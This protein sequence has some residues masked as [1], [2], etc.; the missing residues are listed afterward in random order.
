MAIVFV[1]RV[2]RV[3]VANTHTIVWI[4]LE[5]QDMSASW[6]LIQS[7][8]FLQNRIQSFTGTYFFGFVKIGIPVVPG[9]IVPVHKTNQM[10]TGEL[11][12]GQ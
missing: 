7:L 8:I 4:N 2:L 9:L 11:M 5:L 10:Y 12:Q 1:S 3:R 6:Y